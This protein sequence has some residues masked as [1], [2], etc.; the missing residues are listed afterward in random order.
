MHRLSWLALSAIIRGRQVPMIPED[1]YNKVRY[2]I[3][4]ESGVLRF[5]EFD[6]V[7]PPDCHDFVEVLRRYLVG[8]PL[9][10]V[11]LNYLR[12]LKCKGNAE[13]MRT[14]IRVVEESRHLCAPYCED[15]QSK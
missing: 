10:D 3:N 4:D 7:D 8:R 2:S 12:E 14:A 6:I 5:K 9:A 13:C 1:C 15:G 11:D